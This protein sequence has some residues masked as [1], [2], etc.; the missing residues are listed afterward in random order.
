[1]KEGETAKFYCKASGVPPPIIQWSR[2]GHKIN[3]GKNVIVQMS[4]AENGRGAESTLVI[5]DVKCE[6]EGRYAATAS[7][8][9][10]CDMSDV[11]LE[12]NDDVH[13]ESILIQYTCC[14][15]FD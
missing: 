6:D 10:G 13:L 4:E 7:N 8:D 1:M 14:V 9:E 5:L 2:S 12:G 11:V 15:I 3:T